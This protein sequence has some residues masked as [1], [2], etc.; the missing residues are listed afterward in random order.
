M[1]KASFILFVFFLA[2]TS[3]AQSKK[4]G[5]NN[6]TPPAE[7]TPVVSEKELSKILA[8]KFEFTERAAYYELSDALAHADQVTTLKLNRL[9]LTEVPKEINSFKNLVELDLSG[10]NISNVNGKLSGLKNLQVLNLSGNA[11]TEI[12][13]DVNSLPSLISLNLSSNKISSGSI[14][15]NSIERIYLNNNDLTSIPSGIEN[16]SQLKTL[17]VH[18]NKITRLDEDLLKLKKLEVLLVQFNK[19]VDEPKAFQHNGIIHYVF[20]PQLVDE[21][22][23]YKALYGGP[24]AYAKSAS[25]AGDESTENTDFLGLGSFGEQVVDYDYNIKTQSVGSGFKRVKVGNHSFKRI[26]KVRTTGAIKVLGCF[27][28]PPAGPVVVG[29]HWIS[30]PNH[31]NNFRLSKIL[32]L[33]EDANKLIDQGPSNAR[34]QKVNKINHRIVRVYRKYLKD[35][36]LKSN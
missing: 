32:Y 7:P 16:L 1:K 31:R 25:S 3:I 35:N 27:L 21:R 14:N 13:S 33:Q 12:P 8:N 18:S 30:S 36:K 34:V 20:Y 5:K 22:Y 29:L 10:N 9:N 19:I 4:G 6:T 11:L 24:V 2:T 26:S 15:S 28:L 17:S 23:L